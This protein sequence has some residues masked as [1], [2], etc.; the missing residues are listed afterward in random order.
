MPRCST[1]QSK[2]RKAQVHCPDLSRHPCQDTQLVIQGLRINS[3]SLNP[4]ERLSVCCL[5]L[6]KLKPQ[7]MLSLKI[8]H[9]ALEFQCYN[10]KD[11][12][13]L[14][15]PASDLRFE[16]KKCLEFIGNPF[17]VSWVKC[18]IH[19]FS[20]RGLRGHREFCGSGGSYSSCTCGYV[21]M[22]T[23]SYSIIIHLFKL[24]SFS[25]SIIYSFLRTFIY[26]Q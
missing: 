26:F 25:H 18:H 1:G 21:G 15:F 2:L 3:R 16:H 11:S 10:F 5:V 4:E 23:S 22:S 8:L 7:L 9:P 20:V 17:P 6:L 13:E 12:A 14:G 24:F 19:K